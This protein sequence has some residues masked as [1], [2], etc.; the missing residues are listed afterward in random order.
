MLSINL[1]VRSRRRISSSKPYSQKFNSSRIEKHNK[2]A[3]DRRLR[4]PVMPVYTS[5]KVLKGFVNG[6]L[7]SSDRDSVQRPASSVLSP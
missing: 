5:G 3:S 1:Y 7:M 6:L 4:Q 2:R